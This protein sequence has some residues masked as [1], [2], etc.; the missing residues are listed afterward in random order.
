MAVRCGDVVD[1]K[2]LQSKADDYYCR[3]YKVMLKKA[4]PLVM[5]SRWMNIYLFKDNKCK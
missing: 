1:C 2:W 5:L 3:K 4:P